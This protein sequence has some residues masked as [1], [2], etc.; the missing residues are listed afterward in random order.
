MS[1]IFA[2]VCLI[3]TATQ[4]LTDSLQND[5]QSM[6]PT[7][8]STSGPTFLKNSVFSSLV[9][10]ESNTDYRYQSA[11][12]SLNAMSSPKQDLSR[13]DPTHSSTGLT[14]ESSQPDS[15]PTPHLTNGTSRPDLGSSAYQTNGTSRPDS[16]PTTDI[17]N[18]TSRPD[19]GSST[20]LTNGTSRPDSGSSSP[21]LTPY[22]LYQQNWCRGML[23]SS[24][25]KG[26]PDS[27]NLTQFE[28]KYVI[29]EYRSLWYRTCYLPFRGVGIA[30]LLFDRGMGIANSALREAVGSATNAF[31][32]SSSVPVV[33]DRLRDM[34]V[35][36]RPQ[37]N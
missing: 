23:R 3:S 21:I 25:P 22:E 32:P 34:L 24:A 1:P 12:S 18:G 14:N 8:G 11:N 4:V 9:P 29:P 30:S 31:G 33:M 13:P 5:S 15:S 2:I 36:V 20:L 10:N 26:I 27:S 35:A 6:A 16:S 7:T 17:S 19:S 37:N 28:E